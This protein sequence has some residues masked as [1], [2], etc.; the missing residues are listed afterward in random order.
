MLVSQ[1]STATRPGWRTYIGMDEPAID[2]AADRAANA[3]Q[4]VLLG[5]GEDGAGRC[6]L[7]CTAGPGGGGGGINGRQQR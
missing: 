7:L 3:H 2:R 1:S 6:V 4:A 5:V